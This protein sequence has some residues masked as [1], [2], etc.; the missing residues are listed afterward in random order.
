MI[1]DFIPSQPRSSQQGE[2]VQTGEAGQW[3]LQ[4]KRVSL[5]GLRRHLVVV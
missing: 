2:S 5:P 4:K 1:S 3:W